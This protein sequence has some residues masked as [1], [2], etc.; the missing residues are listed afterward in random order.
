L[1]VYGHNGRLW[2]VGTPPQRTRFCPRRESL[3]QHRLLALYLGLQP[4]LI[5]RRDVLHFAPEPPLRHLLTTAY[6]PRS[7][8]T[9]DIGPGRADLCET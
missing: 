1:S 5:E 9:A 3:E 4:E 7:Y 2:S 6:G 8:V